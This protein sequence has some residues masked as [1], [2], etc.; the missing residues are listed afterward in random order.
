MSEWI[1]QFA[2]REFISAPAVCR[3]AANLAGR[4]DA[5]RV[6][7][8]IDRMA[9]SVLPGQ[10]DPIGVVMRSWSRQDPGAAQEWLNDNRDSPS[11]DAATVSFIQIAAIDDPAVRRA[12]IETLHDEALRTQFMRRFDESQKA[13]AGGR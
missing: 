12:W 2:G 6:I 5:P 13:A 3:L 11:Y 10:P 1:E 9:A 7:E 4:M 8:I